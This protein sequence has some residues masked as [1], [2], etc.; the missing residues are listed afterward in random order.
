MTPEEFTEAMQK[1]ARGGDPEMDHSKADDLL[2][3]ALRDLGYGDGIKIYEKIH[4][5]FA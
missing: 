4:K 3:R 5:W 1:V 2:C